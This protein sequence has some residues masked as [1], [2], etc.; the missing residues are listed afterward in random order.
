MATSP[1]YVARGEFGCDFCDSCNVDRGFNSGFS[2]DPRGCGSI[3]EGATIVSIF[4]TS[5]GTQLFATITSVVAVH[6]AVTIIWASSDL[7]LFPSDVAANRS[8]LFTNYNASSNADVGL[9]EAAKIGISIGV[10]LGVTIILILIWTWLLNVRRRRKQFDGKARNGAGELDGE[11]KIWKR[12]FGHEWRAEL[13]PDGRPS[14]LATESAK[15]TEL[16]VQQI[17]VELP[18]SYQYPKVAAE[19]GEDTRVSGKP[20]DEG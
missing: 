14:Q 16:A 20:N 15:P 10:A 4:P 5:G 11:Q 8:A 12:F 18:G 17:P 9:T 19:A 2:Y 13:P 3:V 6:E 1:S 7:G